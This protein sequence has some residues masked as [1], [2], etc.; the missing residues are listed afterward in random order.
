MPLTSS[1]GKDC[2]SPVSSLLLT[3]PSY[4]LDGKGTVGE[5]R[6]FLCGDKGFIVIPKASIHSTHQW[7]LQCVR[8]HNKISCFVFCP[9]GMPSA[10]ETGTASRNSLSNINHVKSSFCWLAN[11][12]AEQHERCYCCL[13]YVSIGTIERGFRWRCLSAP[14]SLTRLHL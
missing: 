10:L 1:K 14:G 2:G 6:L 7:P 3:A 13:N 4:W 9:R 5:M 8:P 11:E 12:E